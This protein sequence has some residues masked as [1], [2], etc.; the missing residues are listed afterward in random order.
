[1]N[2]DQFFNVIDFGSSI[3]RF[4]VFNDKSNQV[5]SESIPVNFEKSFT[6]HIDL[7]N[8]TVKKAEKKISSHIE[9]LILITDSKDTISI[10][11]CFAK[12][13]DK[14]ENINK[15]YANII[16]EV[17]HIISSYHSKYIIIHSILNKCII[18]SIEHYDLPK[19][20]K[21]IN[22]I[23]VDLKFIC[24]PKLFINKVNQKFIENNLNIS[25]IFCTSYLKSLS[26]VKKLNLKNISF[27]DIGWERSSFFNF[28]HN[29]LNF[30]QTISIGS[31]H[32]T[33]DISKIFK[34]STDEAEIIK[35][36][37]NKSETEFSYD[38]IKNENHFQINQFFNKNISIDLLKKVILYRIQEIFD[39]IYEKSNIKNSNFDFNFNNLFLIGQGSQLFNNN[40]FHIRDKF[41][42]NSIK[43]YGETDETIC[44]AGLNYYL[45]KYESYKFSDKKLGLFERF[46]NI[47]SK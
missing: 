29:K 16:K 32:I 28:N 26:Y 10:D 20:I 37:F 5:F 18:D 38:K 8:N 39:L 14:A 4:T 17:S 43:I 42:F 9:N 7:I 23:K 12:I 41:E 35:K 22:N 1:M 40:L 34:I 2:K 25:N 45:S 24:Y 44:E 13:F 3:I 46:F 36:S 6:N 27:L 15:V 19:N 33:K 21:K 31:F 30:M 47:F 11:I